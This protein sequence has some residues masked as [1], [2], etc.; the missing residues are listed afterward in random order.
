M[1]KL[2]FA[3]HNKNKFAEVQSMMPK[4]IELLSL[5]DLNFNDEIE[6]TGTSLQ[7]N[8]LIKARYIFEKTSLAVISDDTGLEVD[9]LDGAPGVYSA[10]YAGDNANSEQNMDKLL[11]A[12]EHI[13][14]RQARFRT[15]IAYINAD[16]KETLLEGRVE[17]HI[18]KKRQ[19][20]E[21]FGYDPIFLPENGLRSFAE[22]TREEKNKISHR[23]RA[24][25]ALLE[26]LGA[27]YS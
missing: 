14:Q 21:G 12:M 16:G 9:A 27:N 2:I 1:S 4:G 3:T 19:G 15:V 5:T 6:E 23:G 25:K 13:D 11:A 24:F 17:G 7:E 18:A 26:K 20:G 8:A 22:Y 10:R